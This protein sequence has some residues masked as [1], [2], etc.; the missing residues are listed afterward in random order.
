MPVKSLTEY[1]T[2][3]CRV[4]IENYDPVKVLKYKNTYDDV[5][6]LL[7]AKPLETF[8]GRCD[9][10]NKLSKLG[11]LDDSVVKENTILLKIS[12]KYNKNR[13]VYIGRDKIYSFTTNDHIL[14][15]IYNTGN[16][17]IPYSIAVGEENVFFLSPPGKYTGKS[18]N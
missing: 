7:C 8:F 16:N 15:F 13:Y 11:S 5:I 10:T 3:C 14:K 17:M 6:T 1:D 18:K 12:E 9:V 4:E 2:K